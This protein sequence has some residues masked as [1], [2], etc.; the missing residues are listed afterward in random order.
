MIELNFGKSIYYSTPHPDDVSASSNDMIIRIPE[1]GDLKSMPIGSS[2]NY[3]SQAEAELIT[4][5]PKKSRQIFPAVTFHIRKDGEFD[6]EQRIIIPWVKEREEWVSIYYK[7]WIES[8]PHDDET[9][10]GPYHLDEYCRRKIL[11]AFDIPFMSTENVVQSYPH[12]PIF[13]IRSGKV[14]SLEDI[15]KTNPGM[16]KEIGDRE[17]I[18]TYSLTFNVPNDEETWAV[19]WNSKEKKWKLSSKEQ[20]GLFFRWFYYS[21]IGEE[22]IYEEHSRLAYETILGA[23]GL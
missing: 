21:G 1:Q 11:E 8:F 12:F 15:A 17:Q 16:L 4:F 14:F 20:D 2:I 23:F 22:T 19:D 10:C 7:K 13:Q 9:Y 3:L 5:I 18:S 6:I